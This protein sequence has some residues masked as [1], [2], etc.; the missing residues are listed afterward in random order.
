M[1]LQVNTSQA[2]EAAKRLS[3]EEGLISGISSGAA[4][5]AALEVGR[6]EESKG[7]LIV[8]FCD[9]YAGLF[10]ISGGGVA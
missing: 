7:K 5:H 2:I 1:F 8:W 9:S 4:L 10:F 6:R 3:F